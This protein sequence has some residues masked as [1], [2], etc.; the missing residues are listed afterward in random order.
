[1]DCVDPPFQDPPEGKWHCP[2]CPP[3]PPEGQQFCP[4]SHFPGR[5]FPDQPQDTQLTPAADRE[6]SVASS[7]RSIAEVG[8]PAP[9]FRSK[10]NK[11]SMGR[12]KKRAPKPTAISD[13][14][15]NDDPV[16]V[17]TMMTLTRTRVRVPTT[18]SASAKGRVRATSPDEVLPT[19]SRK[20]K[21]QREPS[22][23]KVR[24]R[25][26][27]QRGRKGKEREE[28]EAPRGMFDDILT[29]E[30]RNTSNTT[31]L[32]TDKIM[33]ERSRQ[34]AEVSQVVR[35]KRNQLTNDDIYKEQT[36]APTATDRVVLTQHSRH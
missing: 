9:P 7:S 11:K 15:D 34:I 19:P 4:N 3:I 18:K 29:P 28:D 32:N 8:T 31:P 16:D 12:S 23:A 26:P 5:H 17:E 21:R 2:I 14:S 13:G 36:R 6:P 22:P 20:R 27:A 33:F 35:I 24:L 30:E 1:M 10:R 25:I